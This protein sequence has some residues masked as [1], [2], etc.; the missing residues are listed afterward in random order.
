MSQEELRI[1]LNNWIDKS[2]VKAKYVAL[3]LGIEE[4][5]FCRFRKNARDLF[6]ED[7]ERLEKYLADKL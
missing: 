3:D 6:I 4:S 7:A 5:V 1:K 2:H